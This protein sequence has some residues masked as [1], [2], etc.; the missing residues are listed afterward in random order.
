M[1]RGEFNCDPHSSSIVIK[2]IT[3]KS[4]KFL[5]NNFYAAKCYVTQNVV[6]MRSIYSVSKVFRHNDT[7]GN[8]QAKR[9]IMHCDVCG[10]QPLL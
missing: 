7:L 8:T 2:T 9:R 5:K 1:D 10:R 3:I 6:F 4:K